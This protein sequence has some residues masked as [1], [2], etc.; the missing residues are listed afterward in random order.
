M[1]FLGPSNKVNN[2][3]IVNV[4]LMLN[5]LSCYEV[6]IHDARKSVSLGSRVQ[7]VTLPDK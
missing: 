2:G 7:H 3:F 1:Q 4:I 5:T 6:I